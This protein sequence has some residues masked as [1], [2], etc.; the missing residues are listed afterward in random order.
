M[1]VEITVKT[2]KGKKSTKKDVDKTVDLLVKLLELIEPK[3]KG[4]KTQSNGSY[5]RTGMIYEK[6]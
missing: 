2:G 6:K 3:L 4:Y 5:D 1:I